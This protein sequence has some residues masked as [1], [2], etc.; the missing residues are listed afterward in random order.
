MPE[1]IYPPYVIGISNKI[2]KFMNIDHYPLIS[3]NGFEG[4]LLSVKFNG[5]NVHEHRDMKFFKGWTPFR[6]NVVTQAPEQGAKLY[7][8]DELID[9]KVGDLHCYYASEQKHY[10]TEVEGNTPRVLWMFGAHRPL[11]DYYEMSLQNK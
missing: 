5:E 11:K 9:I 2:R 7:V 3:E 6:C 1:K 4:V 8:E 10:V